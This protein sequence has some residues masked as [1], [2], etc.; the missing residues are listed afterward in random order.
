MQQQPKVGIYSGAFDPVHNGH[1]QF[2]LDAARVGGL[3]KV[4]F[5]VEPRPRHKQGVKA[6]EHRVAMVKLA[7]QTHANLG[8]IV[9]DQQR[10]TVHDTW[11]KLQAR[12]QGADIS[13]IMGNDVFGHLSHWPQLDM[14]SAS[15]TFLV[16]LRGGAVP[17][18]A[19]HVTMIE[20]SRHVRLCYKV[21]ASDLPT[22]ASR[23]IRAHLRQGVVPDVLD[24]RVA[25]Y[26]AK[27]KLY[28]D[29]D[30]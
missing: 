8:I 1:V 28:T 17:E 6:M 7:V 18:V 24:A 26:I 3:D 30:V 4:F 9:L 21:F 12:L 13:M 22:V 23:T 19:R 11:P 2:A 5:L 27:Y 16:G 29:T 14:L 20:H 25:A 10:F 15:A